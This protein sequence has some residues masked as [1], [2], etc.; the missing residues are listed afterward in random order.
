M[1]HFW[2]TMGALEFNNTPMAVAQM[3]QEARIS[4][5]IN[6]E[7]KRQGDSILAEIGIKPS[8][9]ITMFYNQIVRQRGLPFEARIPNDETIKALNEDLS[10]KKR[11]SSVEELMDDLNS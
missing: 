1:H 11:F 10:T 3:T 6:A 8:Q 5:R 4:S 2:R 7:L 9:A